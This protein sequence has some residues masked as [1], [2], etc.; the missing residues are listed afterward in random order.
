MR[1]HW[2]LKGQW[3][4]GRQKP[5]G[6]TTYSNPLILLPTP[7]HIHTSGACVFPVLTST[8]TQNT[9]PSCWDGPSLRQF[10][11]ANAHPFTN[12]TLVFICVPVLRDISKVLGEILPFFTRP[13]FR[14]SHSLH[15]YPLTPF[16]CVMCVRAFRQ[17]GRTTEVIRTPLRHF[18]KYQGASVINREAG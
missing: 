7:F 17:Q 8:P 16:A 18:G 11:P 1:K 5:Q 4:L 6:S 3:M 12:P 2:P 13:S 14:E 9:Q 10:F 15:Q